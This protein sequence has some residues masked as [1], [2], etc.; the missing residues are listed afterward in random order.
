MVLLLLHVMNE[1]QLTLRKVQSYTGERSLVIVL[2][3]RFTSQIGVEKG[4][5]MKVQLKNKQIILEKAEI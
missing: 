4:N 5:F 1:K 2:P 3:K